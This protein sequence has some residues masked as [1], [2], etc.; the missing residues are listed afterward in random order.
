[1][2][3]LSVPFIPFVVR[4]NQIAILNPEGVSVVVIQFKT[5]E[6]YI[7][8]FKVLPIEETYPFLFYCLVCFRS[9][10]GYE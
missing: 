5:F 10:W 9:T 6:F 4:Y 7:P 3:K 8:A 1:M 2:T